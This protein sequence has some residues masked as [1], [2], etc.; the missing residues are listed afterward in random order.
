MV[1]QG[2]AEGSHALGRQACQPSVPISVH[3]H[4]VSFFVV[5]ANII[6][7]YFVLVS[8]QLCIPVIYPLAHA[9]LSLSFLWI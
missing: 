7:S 2:V 3:S 1:G 9:E 5:V 8:S 4:K 6:L